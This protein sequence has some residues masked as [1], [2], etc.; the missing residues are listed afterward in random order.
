MYYSRRKTRSIK[1]TNRYYIKRI[2]SLFKKLQSEVKLRTKITNSQ[3]IKIYKRE[4]NDK[5]IGKN[6]LMELSI[7]K[8]KY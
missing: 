4:Y 3:I 6:E 1:L 7:R 5:S 2:Q 8:T